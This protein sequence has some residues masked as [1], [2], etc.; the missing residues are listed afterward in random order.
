MYLCGHGKNHA[1]TK[2]VAEIAICA[3]TD[4]RKKTMSVSYKTI[5]RRCDEPMKRSMEKCNTPFFKRWEC[6]KECD[7]CF[8]CIHKDE[9]G[10]ETH[11][12]VKR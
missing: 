6:T 10:N 9:N 11:T 5:S 4:Q 1:I 12:K 2:D 3:S 8:C 7:K